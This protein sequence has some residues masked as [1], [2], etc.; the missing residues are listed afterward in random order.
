MNHQHYIDANQA[1]WDETA[2]IHHDW[3]FQQL[4]DKVAAPGFNALD[5]VET[6]SF[7]RMGLPGKAVIQLGCNNGQQLISLYRAGAARCCGVDFSA[8]FID[9]ARTLADAAGAVIDFICAD[10]YS[11][12]QQAPGKFD[13]V[14]VNVGVLGWM[15][16]LDGFFAVI[17]TLLGPGGQLFIYEMHPVL[18]MFEPETGLVVT[19]SYLRRQPFELDEADYLDPTKKAAAT[20]FWFHHPLGEIVTTCIKHGMTLTALQEYQHDISATYRDFEQAAHAL[21]MCYTLL[22]TKNAVTA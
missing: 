20:S 21:P 2:T 4:R 17:A 15:P 13:I 14:Y 7:E 22:A 18:D 3:Y 10:I 19:Q 11:L 16:D 5:A 8:P 12:P 1:R 9:Q 6:V